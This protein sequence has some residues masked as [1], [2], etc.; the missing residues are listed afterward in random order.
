[1]NDEHFLDSFLRPKSVALVGV[2]QKTGRGTFNILES[3]IDFG[4]KGDIYP[5][6]PIAIEI[7]GFKA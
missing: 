6:N 5:V 7:L 4:Y 3:L 2:S 1:M